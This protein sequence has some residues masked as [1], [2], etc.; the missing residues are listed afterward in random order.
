MSIRTSW[1][2]LAVSLLFFFS[3]S[4]SFGQEPTEIFTSLDHC[5]AYHTEKSMI[6]TPRVLVTGKNCDIQTTLASKGQQF[7][8]QIDIPLAGFHSGNGSRDSHVA[9]MLNHDKKN[10]LR[11]TSQE[12]S[13]GLLQAAGDSGKL[14]IKGTLLVNGREYPVA[15]VAEFGQNLAG[16]FVRGKIIASFSDFGLEPPVVGPFGLVANTSEAVELHYSLQSSRI[17]GLEKF[18]PAPK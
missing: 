15:S 14:P 11:F 3:G 9:G 1:P 4:M 10:S 12:L 16:Y 7:V 13:A 8:V 5:V 2:M 17:A 6:F 18:L